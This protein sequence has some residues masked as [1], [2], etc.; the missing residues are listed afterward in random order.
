MKKIDSKKERLSFAA[1]IV[2]QL[3]A[4]WLCMKGLSGK[5]ITGARGQG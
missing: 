2:G 3:E 4:I 1:C 5:R